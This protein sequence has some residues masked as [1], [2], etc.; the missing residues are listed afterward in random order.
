MR[1]PQRRRFQSCA[2]V[3]EWTVGSSPTWIDLQIPEPK[4]VST[5]PIKRVRQADILYGSLRGRSRPEAY[6]SEE[7]PK[8]SSELPC[9]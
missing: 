2:H 5:R 3:F 4:P 7:V 1:Q 8:W 9:S 6:R